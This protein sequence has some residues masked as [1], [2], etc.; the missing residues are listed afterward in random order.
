MDSLMKFV[1]TSALACG[2]ALASVPADARVAYTINARPV[3]YEVQHYMAM[4]GL[5]PG[6]YW[7]DRAGTW[8][9]GDSN[10]CV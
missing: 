1:A 4:N 9:G 5:P 8:V 2:L 10:G 3:T 6:H 7:L